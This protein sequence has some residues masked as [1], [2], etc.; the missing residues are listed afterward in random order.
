[1]ETNTSRAETKGSQGEET[2]LGGIIPDNC[3]R[4][5]TSLFRLYSLS[6][7]H[8]SLGIILSVIFFMIMN[9]KLTI[10]LIP[11]KEGSVLVWVLTVADLSC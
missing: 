10:C 8:L 3:A 2:R 9:G 5:K 7:C 6:A 4:R 11:S 1:M